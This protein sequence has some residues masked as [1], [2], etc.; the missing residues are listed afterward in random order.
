MNVHAV[1]NKQ[2]IGASRYR[3]HPTSDIRR[4]RMPVH[5]GHWWGRYE[6]TWRGGNPRIF[7][8]S[9]D[10]AKSKVIFSTLQYQLPGRQAGL[11]GFKLPRMRMVIV[12]E[13]RGCSQEDSFR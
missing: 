10:P 7:T 6:S 12:C 4:G 3:Q 1:K 5:V 8:C 2:S 9:S 13:P 11:R